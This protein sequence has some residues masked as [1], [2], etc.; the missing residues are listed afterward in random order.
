MAPLMKP[1][2]CALLVLDSADEPAPQNRAAEV[3][4]ARD[5][6]LKAAA[7]CGIPAFLALRDLDT[8]ACISKPTCQQI[9]SPPMPGNPWGE[10]PSAWR[11]P[12]RVDRHCSFAGTG[13][14][15]ASPSQ[16]SM[17]L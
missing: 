15:N 1:S 10:T 8:A 4:A 3:T 7:Q 11:S 12:A 14:T 17:P 9:Y 6:I 5:R 13:S 2:E 16:P